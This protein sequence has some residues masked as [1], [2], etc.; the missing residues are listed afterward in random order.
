MNSAVVRDFLSYRVCIMNNINTYCALYVSGLMWCVVTLLLSCMVFV[1]LLVV[2]CLTRCMCYLYVG[3][4]WVLLL[5]LFSLVM[6]VVE[7]VMVICHHCCRGSARIVCVMVSQLEQCSIL[8]PFAIE[9]AALVAAGSGARCVAGG[10]CS[11]G[12][13]ASNYF[14]NYGKRNVGQS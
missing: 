14:Q 10:R 2:L 11:D 6:V 7:V 9:L 13:N 1:L 5:L 12:T 4:L 8:A 3:V